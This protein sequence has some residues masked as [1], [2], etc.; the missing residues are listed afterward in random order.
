[1]PGSGWI[2]L[3]DRPAP[4]VCRSVPCDLGRHACS[5]KTSRRRFQLGSLSSRQILYLLR[6][7]RRS[8]YLRQS[9]VWKISH[10]TKALPETQFTR[11]THSDRW[12]SATRPPRRLRKSRAIAGL[13]PPQFS[14]ARCILIPNKPGICRCA[15]AFRV[16]S[17][18]IERYAFTKNPKPTWWGIGKYRG[19]SISSLQKGQP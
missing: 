13:E 12:W 4:R 2:V 6:S 18:G 14:R 19:C 5:R 3:P 1:M 17:L 11:E 16:N 8:E 15:T 10:R 9:A 7:Q